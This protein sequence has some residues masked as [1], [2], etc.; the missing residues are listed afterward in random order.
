MAVEMNELAWTKRIWAFLNEQHP[1][2]GLRLGRERQVWDKTRVDILTDQLAI[3]VDWAYKHWEAIGQ[4]IWYAHNFERKPGVCLLSSDFIDD[5]KHIY[6]CEVN[7]ISQDIALWLVDTTKNVIL[8][9][10]QHYALP[11]I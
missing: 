7:C 10:G 6:R 5:S 9:A 11:E 4:A 2:Y 1:D 3:E 8:I